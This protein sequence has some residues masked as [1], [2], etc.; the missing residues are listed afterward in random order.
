MLLE[1]RTFALNSGYFARLDYVSFFAQEVAFSP[2][3]QGGAHSGNT[4]S[5][6]NIARVLLIRN[7]VA[8]NFLNVACTI[9]D[10]GAL[11]AI[12]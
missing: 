7:F 9:G 6:R 10:S 11:G 2:E 1:Y 4:G 5:A 12:L 3:V 8:N